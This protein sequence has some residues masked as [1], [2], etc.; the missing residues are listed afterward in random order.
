[1]ESLL[2]ASVGSFVI[3]TV[4]ILGFAAYMTGQAL[5]A[6]WRPLWQLFVYCALLAGASRFLIFSLFDGEL[7]SGSGYVI[8]AAVLMGMAGFAFR[9]TRARKMVTQYPW[10]Y[11]RTGIFG[12]RSRH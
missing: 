8:D 1:M 5:A 3:V 2:G 12:W 4:V 6:T 11:E 10:L 7:L 9:L